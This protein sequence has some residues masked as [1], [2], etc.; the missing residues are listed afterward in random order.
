MKSRHIIFLA[1]LLSVAWSLN[2]HSQVTV[3][4]KM[5]SLQMLMGKLN[6]LNIEVVEPVSSKGVFPQFAN[7]AEPG[8]V[9]GL[10]G[11]SIEVRT[12][13]SADTVEVG[14]GRRK[15]SFRYPVQAFDSGFYKLPEIYYVSGTDTARCGGINVKVVPVKVAE[16]DSI[17][18]YGPVVDPAGKQFFD[19]IPDWLVDF[20]WLILIVLLAIAAFVFVSLKKKR[21]LPVLRKPKPEP[22]P[23]DMAVKALEKLKEKKLWEQGFEK[24]YYTELTEIIRVY[25]FKRFG[26]NAMEMT[27]RQIMQN[28]A[29]SQE[30]KEKRSYI[31]QI[32]D[33]ADFV[34][35]AKVRPLPQDNVASWERAM[36]FVTETKPVPAAVM[37]DSKDSVPGGTPTASGTG[38]TQK[39]G[40]ER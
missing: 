4:A 2:L 30:L 27:S 31:R 20:W 28:L 8:G 18:D 39:K 22:N 17:S 5:D 19:F 26:I 35:F 37:D 21:K 29:A 34:K 3:S 14:N 38:K 25:L 7:P 12:A 16:T 10:C 11:D 9:V 32:L 15:I 23:Y 33:M 1:L 24:Q 36:T 6:S 13:Y 40:G